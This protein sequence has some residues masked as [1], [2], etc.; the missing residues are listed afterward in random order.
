MSSLV[1]RQLDVLRDRFALALPGRT[2]SRSFY[3]H[4]QHRA[5]DLERGV[6]TLLMRKR[7]PVDDWSIELEL[8]LIGQLQNPDRDAVPADTENLELELEAELQAICRNPGNDMPRIIVR[9]VQTSSQIEHPFGWVA[10]E[11][12]VGPIDAAM[13]DDSE[14][15][16]PTLT[17]PSSFAG[18]QVDIDIPPHESRTEH[19]RWL[20]RNYASSRPELSTT[21]EL[22]P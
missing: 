2:V 20:E 3:D 11:I 8:S 4:A 15:Y 13:A 18:M 12:T 10:M 14:L 21:V 17:L 5:D 9:S 16:P 1:R 7:R 6:V 19:E 22:K